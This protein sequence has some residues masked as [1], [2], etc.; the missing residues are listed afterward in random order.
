VR[1]ASLRH[2]TGASASLLAVLSL[3]CGAAAYAQTT[4][5]LDTFTATTTAMTPQ[6]VTLKIVVR[7]WSDDSARA[8]VL[9]ALGN[10]AEARAALGAL[11][12]VGYL[13][14]SGS[15]IGYAVKYAYRVKT[16]HGERVTFV[17][18][19]PIG[20]YGLKPW[21]AEGASGPSSLPYSVVEL[22]L[23]GGAGVGTLSLAADVKLDATAAV[24]S[25]AAKPGAA[26]VLANAK[27]EPKPYWANAH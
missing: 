16:D 15:A 23:G 22:E 5:V 11:P 27:L 9:A 25:L 14:H 2:G 12:T 3:A 21:V 13:W 19:R 10:E 6:D 18:D 20:V 7:D 24:V 17:T 8:D 4:P 26:P 1:N